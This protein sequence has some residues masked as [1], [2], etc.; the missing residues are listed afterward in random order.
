MGLISDVKTETWNQLITHF[1]RE[2]WEVIF[3]YDNFDKGIDYNAV[4][5]QK[6]EEKIEF[7]WDNWTEGEIRGSDIM[8]NEIRRMLGTLP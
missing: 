2:G 7:T 5:L 3:N 1:E 4:T 6:G 8:L